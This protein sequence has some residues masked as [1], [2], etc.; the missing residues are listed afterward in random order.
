MTARLRRGI[1]HARGFT[2]DHSVVEGHLR[3]S[4]QGRPRTLHELKEQL[5]S[6]LMYKKLYVIKV[7]I[8]PSVNKVLLEKVKAY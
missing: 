7:P 3:G 5:N 2:T 1:P 8:V 6:A 4:Q